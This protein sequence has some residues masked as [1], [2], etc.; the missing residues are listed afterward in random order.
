M[1]KKLIVALA[2]AAGIIAG[3]AAPANIIYFQD[4]SDKEISTAV[5]PTQ[6]RFRPEDEISIIINCPSA[7]LMSQFNL[8][9]ITRY[10]GNDRLTSGGGNTGVCG[11]TID[12]KGDIDFPVIGK[13]HVAGLTRSDVAALIK[14]EL[15][16]RDLVRDPVVTVDF[17]NLTVSLM[18]EVARPGRYSITRDHMTVLD[19]LAQAGDLTITGRRDNIRVIRE[20]DGVQHTYLLDLRSAEELAKSPAYYLCQ[21]D[22][23][24]VEP[25]EM[26]TRQSTVNGNTVMSASF[27]ISIASLAAT[28]TSTITVVALRLQNM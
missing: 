20:E 1:N 4:T 21:N 16:S 22:V 14:K 19:A 27:W 11:Y 23:I 7:E 6:I 2:F 12:D 8:P 26:R 9:Y 5:D 18:G 24:Y 28:L 25:N 17:M 3:C 15:Q 13:I 10:L